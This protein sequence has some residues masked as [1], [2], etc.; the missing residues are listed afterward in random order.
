[1]ASETSAFPTDD[2]VVSAKSAGLRYVNDCQP[3]FGR[4]KCGKGFRYVDSSGQ[5]IRD[6]ALIR[7]AQSLGIPPAWQEVWICPWENGHIQATGRDAKGRKQYRYHP[8]WRT[9]RDEAKYERMVSFGRMLPSLRE[10][11]A[12]ALE[13]P[14]FPR[15][16]V[17]AIIVRLLETTL[18]RV[19]NE[20]YARTN[21]SFG[22][23]TLRHRHVRISGDEVKFQFRGKSRV[24]HALRLHDR[25][26]AVII[27]RM[28]DLP[29]QELFQYIDDAGERHAVSSEDVNEYLRTLTG[30][31][32]T[33]KDFR[34]WAGTLEAAVALLGLAPYETPAQA[35]KNVDEAIK[36]V[37]GKLGNT[38]RICRNCY[39]HPLLLEGYLDE[40]QWA[41]WQA[42]LSNKTGGGTS[43]GME[44]VILTLFERRLAAEKT[45][46]K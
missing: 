30:E 10:K 17:L 27:K 38:P 21:Q 26:L 16:K 1:M 36:A 28:R 6:K 34:T 12:L 41:L 15:E 37:A 13:L 22:L 42:D 20:E 31:D 32:Y 25:R 2:P 35:K 7:R 29:G 14:G 45:C 46:E 19:G 8:Q 4:Q 40:Q 9:V 33:A 3:G 44:D 23:T 18:M 5:S 11:I 43:A 39:V 24:Q